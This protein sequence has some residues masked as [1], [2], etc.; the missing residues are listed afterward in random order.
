MQIQLVTKYSS[1]F[2]ETKSVIERTLREFPYLIEAYKEY[3]GVL[4]K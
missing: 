2:R 4:K 3:W 1:D